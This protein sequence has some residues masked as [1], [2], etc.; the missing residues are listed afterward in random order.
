VVLHLTKQQLALKQLK[1]VG[2]C[3]A[4]YATNKVGQPVNNY[5]HP[6]TLQIVGPIPN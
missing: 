1:T 5:Y 6:V 2:D 4:V 3:Y